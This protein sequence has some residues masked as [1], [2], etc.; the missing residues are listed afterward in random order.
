MLYL[1]G[2]SGHAKVVIEIAETLGEQIVCLFDQNP[3]I[4]SILGY[5]VKQ[6]IPDDFNSKETSL[7]ITIGDNLTRKKIAETYP[8]IY[9]TLIHPKSNISTRAEIREGTIVMAGVSINSEAKIGKHAI[10]NTNCSV[11]H[12]CVIK[13]YVHISPNATLAGNV[14]VGEGVHIGVGACVIPGI[15]IGKWATIG[16]GSVIIRDVPDYATVV[17]NP[18]RIIKIKDN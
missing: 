18:G 14:S 15:K 12:D 7:L 2:A 16:A 5:P 1:F 11:D 9:K 4:K 13:D 8:F 6:N 10:I 3:A 17:G